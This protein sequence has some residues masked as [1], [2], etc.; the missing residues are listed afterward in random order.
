MS[1]VVA[2][3]ISPSPVV[4]APARTQPA[5]AS[6]PDAEA[7]LAAEGLVD[8]RT[9]VP[10]LEV[11]LK[12]AIAA[13]FMGEAV[14]GAGRACYLQRPAAQKLAR[15]QEALS[16]RQPG[17][18]LL[19][20]DCL[21]PRQVQRRMWGL[22]RG[23]PQQNYVARPDPGSMHNHG[24]AVDISIADE[25]GEALD[26]GTAFDHF[27]PLAQPRFEDRYLRAG[28][29]TPEQVENRRL[30][31]EVMTEAGWRGIR[32]EW[33]HFEAF[34]IREIRQRFPLVEA[35]PDQQ[36]GAPHQAAAASVSR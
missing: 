30:L 4:A 14:Y 15:A 36:S 2:A 29:L 23:T 18:R 22:V 31:R 28:K 5:V 21:R 7:T 24:A 3:G 17:W 25:N 20:G 35:W 6:G 27:G 16:R 26:M 9:V 34:P 11:R 13:N 1:F 32:N 8:A 12:Y 33:W 19:V 10:E